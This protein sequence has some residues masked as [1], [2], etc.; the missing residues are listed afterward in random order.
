MS[1]KP[2]EGIKVLDLTRVLAGPYCTMVLRNLGAEIIKI[3]RPKY[4][5]D[6]QGFGPF[7][8]GESVYFISINRGKKSIE[9]NLKSEDGKKVFFE[10]LN[11]VDI[12]AENFKLGTMEKL[13]LGYEVL[14][15]KKPD[16]IYAA[17]SGFG[18][19]GPYSARPAYDMIV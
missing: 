12:V 19:S 17:M 10:L 11:Q 2:L 8:D 5:D 1:R 13:G 16:I 6:S 9:L 14:K 18:H 4:G 15:E 7:I 3:E